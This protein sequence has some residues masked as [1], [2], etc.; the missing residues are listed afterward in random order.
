MK[1][2][3]IM[4]HGGNGWRVPISR[5]KY[6]RLAHN[7][8]NFFS[9]KKPIKVFMTYAK[10]ESKSHKKELSVLYNCLKKN[11]FEPSLDFMDPHEFNRDYVAWIDNKM[12]E[13]RYLT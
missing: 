5:V 7:S 12:S 10:E 6:D 8:P 13:V 9:G 2:V 11:N 1:T 4:H 3:I